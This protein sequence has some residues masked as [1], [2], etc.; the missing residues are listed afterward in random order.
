MA[1]RLPR[2]L[3]RWALQVVAV[4]IAMP[5]ST[6]VIY[7]LSTEA[8]APPFWLVQDRMEGF[9]V[10]CGISIF[11][12]PWVALA[13]WCDRKKLSRGAGAGI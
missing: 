4:A 13:R 1:R 3:G 12:A 8:G 2:W 9:S 5:I 11:L 6:A 7:M 10:L